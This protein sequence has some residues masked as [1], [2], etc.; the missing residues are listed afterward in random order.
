MSTGRQMAARIE[1][2]LTE[3]TGWV[4]KTYVYTPPFIETESDIS[5]YLTANDSDQLNVWFIVRRRLST[6]KYGEGG[7]VSTR[8]RS[9]THYFI[10]RGFISVIK[11]KVDDLYSE[12]AFQDL[13]DSIE[14]KLSATTSLGI[15]SPTTFVTGFDA[16]VNFQQFGKYTC[17]ATTITLT[18]TETLSTAYVL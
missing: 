2:Y 3:I 6:R 7:R 15:S 11:D 1:S 9:K 16:D 4:G 14:E 5:E 18:V 8:K 13:I 10:I 17:H 12:E